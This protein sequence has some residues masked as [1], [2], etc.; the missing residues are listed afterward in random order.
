MLIQM[1]CEE[2]G[3]CCC[4]TSGTLLKTLGCSP[5]L[6]PGLFSSSQ[7]QPY[8]CWHLVPG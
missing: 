2:Q 6:N 3:G 8:P 4:H 5:P 1:H 7:L